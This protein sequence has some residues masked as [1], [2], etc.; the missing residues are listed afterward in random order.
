M[1]CHGDMVLEA[2]DEVVHPPFK[3]RACG[4]CH[5][6]HASEYIAVTV[7]AMPGL[8]YECHKQMETG[9][10]GSSIKHLPVEEGKCSECHS[11]HETKL[12]HLLLNR[13]K[14]LC[15]SCH[16]RIVTT[17]ARKGHIAMEEGDCLSC[18]MPHYSEPKYLLNATDPALCIK[19]HPVDTEMLLK[20]HMKPLTKI[21]ECLSCHEPH[22]TEKPG[23]LR[24]VMH[25]PFAK[26]DCKACHE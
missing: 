4:T 13:P 7:M 10:I 5:D 23:M 6:P 1:K 24:K 20:V 11:P 25:S 21:N 18:H 9:L 22:V 19:C 16:E 8:C 2:K 15:L 12:R 14:E 17:T 3:D 26:G